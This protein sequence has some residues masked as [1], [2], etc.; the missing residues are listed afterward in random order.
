M[1]TMKL[2]LHEYVALKIRNAQLSQ[3]EYVCVCVCVVQHEN[4]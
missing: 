2:A 3:L 4:R 1:K